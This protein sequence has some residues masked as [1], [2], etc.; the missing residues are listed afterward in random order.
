METTQKVKD[1]LRLV[2]VR[3]A[4]RLFLLPPVA[5]SL[6]AVYFCACWYFGNTLAEFAPPEDQGGKDNAA[7]AVNLAPADPLT[8]WVLGNLEKASLDPARWPEAIKQYEQAVRLSPNDYRL[9]MDLGR[10]REQSGDP[11]GGEIALRRAVELGP[12]YGYPR[13]YLGNLLLRQGRRDEAFVE[14]RKAGDAIGQLQPQVFVLAWHFYDQDVSALESN[15]ALNVDSKAQLAL[16]LAG[17]ERPDDAVRIWKSIS[18]E[19]RAERT[20]MG[21]QILTALFDAKSFTAAADLE[22]TLAPEQPAQLGKISNEGFEGAIGG[23]DAGFF[24]WHV[25]SVPLAKVSLDPNV[26]HGG[27]RSLQ[28][29]FT[30]YGDLFFTS[31]WQIVPVSADTDYRLSYFVRTDSLVSAGPPIF[32]IYDPQ[33]PKTI[34]AAQTTG[35]TGNNEWQVVNLDF[36]TGPKTQGIAIRTNRIQCPGPC[37]IFGTIWYDDFNLQTI[38]SNAK[39]GA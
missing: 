7:A 38:P 16:F 12:A 37:A 2:D 39:P 20:D 5:I 32:E 21:R 6:I 9:W 4:R 36:K 26:F 8:H 34:L 28:I 15:L 25:S 10:A 1:Q 13:W 19:S 3:G 23:A 31:V 14:L 24:T 17:Q 33:D 18:A 11:V 27:R 30:G 29:A 22:R 35:I